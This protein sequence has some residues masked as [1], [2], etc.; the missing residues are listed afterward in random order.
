MRYRPLAYLSACGAPRGASV[1]PQGGANLRFALFGAPSPLCLA[2]CRGRTFCCAS[3]CA[4]ANLPLPSAKTGVLMPN[5][6]SC[7]RIL[8]RLATAAVL[9]LL[10]IWLVNGPEPTRAAPGFGSLPGT[11]ATAAEPAR[12]F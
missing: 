11:H 4:G 7:T 6:S 8:A 12:I 9:L 2:P 10:G 3:H 1:S 5:P